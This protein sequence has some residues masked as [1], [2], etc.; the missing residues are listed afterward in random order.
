MSSQRAIETQ[1]EKEPGEAE[2]ARRKESEPPAE[3]ACN[4]NNKWRRENRANTRAAVEDPNGKA[5]FLAGEP[6]GDG[7][8]RARPIATLAHSHQEAQSFELAERIREAGHHAGYGPPDHRQRQSDA[9]S[10]DIHQHATYQPHSR[11]GN[12]K[13][14]DDV[15]VVF[16]REMEFFDDHRREDG[17]G[18]PVNVIDGGGKEERADN[19]PAQIFARSDGRRCPVACWTFG[20]VSLLPA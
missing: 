7:L 4:E 15:G 19:P 17:E 20:E 16:V 11:V 14:R 2:R 13:R 1:P 6:F 10:D 3:M 8:A 5:A 9:N 18:L 12:L